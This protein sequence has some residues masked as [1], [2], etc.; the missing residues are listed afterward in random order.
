L[1]ACD[2]SS[3]IAPKSIHLSLVFDDS[4]ESVIYLGKIPFEWKV[5]GP[6]NNNEVVADLRIKVLSTQ[7]ENA[8]FRVKAVAC[9]KGSNEEVEGLSDPIK[10]VSKPDQIRKKRREANQEPLE[11]PTQKKRA[12]S[13]DLIEALAEIRQTQTRSLELLKRLS[14]SSPASIKTPRPYKSEEQ[15]SDDDYVEEESRSYSYSSTSPSSPT[16]QHPRSVFVH[17][18]SK[19]VGA[20][21]SVSAEL[22]CA[23]DLADL[24]S[25]AINT[26]TSEHGSDAVTDLMTNVAPHMKSVL[27]EISISSSTDSIHQ[28]HPNCMCQSLFTEFLA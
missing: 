2:E 18:F 25:T 13:E 9:L 17:Q 19:L 16:P 3:A 7:M 11:V 4:E 12:R 27:P 1:S 26:A 10:I 14:K 8:L 20:F 28:H 22:D 5:S 24:I 21:R 23:V 15:S 6:Q